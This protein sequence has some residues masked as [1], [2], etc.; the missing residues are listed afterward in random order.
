VKLGVPAIVFDEAT[1][2]PNGPSLGWFDVARDGRFLRSRVV[3][4]GAGDARR[5]VLVQNWTAAMGK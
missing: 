3:A 1:I 5:L 4:P 2:G